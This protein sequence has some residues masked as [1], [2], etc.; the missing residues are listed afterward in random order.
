MKKV[1]LALTLIISIAIVA[2]AR[3]TYA[4]DS[5]VLPKT[6]QTTLKNNF[7]SGVSVVKID[8]DFGRIHEYEVILTD[9]TEVTFDRN[10]E[11]DNIETSNSAA[12]PSAFVPKAIQSYVN[13]NQAGARIVGIDKERHGYDVE[14]SNGVEMKFNKQG[15]FL[16]YDD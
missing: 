9:G 3:D 5:S 11:W 12:V 8:K 4:R 13:Q 14:L 2:V 6:A 10:G 7:K 15:Q 1:F 16:R